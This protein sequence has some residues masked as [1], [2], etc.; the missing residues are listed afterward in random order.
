MPTNYPAALD[1]AQ[2]LLIA[3]NNIATSCIGAVGSGSTG[4]A[5]VSATGWPASGF[6]SIESEVVFYDY[7]DVGG[8]NPVLHIP[9]SGPGRGA[10]GT[11]AV[12]HIDGS[13]VELRWVAGYHNYL[14]AAI[15]AI[16]A[17]LGINPQG[18]FTD[19]ATLLGQASPVILSVSSSVTWTFTHTRKR[20]V[21]VQLWRNIDVNT[22]ERFDA[23]MNQLVNSSGTST[24]TIVLPAAMA[25]YIIYQ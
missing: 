7:I 16:E 12:S 3:V 13:K 17:A 25:G 4:I 8:A 18:G 2:D 14:S 10:D 19:V 23:P 20:L 24:V 15:R 11:T 9:S 6:A 22:Y 21:V 5:I 1:I